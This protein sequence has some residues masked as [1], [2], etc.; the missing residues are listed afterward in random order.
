MENT[1]RTFYQE[2]RSK[3]KVG[4]YKDLLEMIEKEI[5]NILDPSEKSEKEMWAL[6]EKANWSLDHDYAR[7]LQARMKLEDELQ[8]QTDEWVSKGSQHTDV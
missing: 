5:N 2:I 6:I 1:L 4:E 7:M 8:R 3:S